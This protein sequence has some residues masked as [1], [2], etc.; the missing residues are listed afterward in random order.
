MKPRLPLT[1]IGG[2][3]GAGKTTLVNRWLREAEGQRIAVLVNDFGALNIDAALIAGARGD[4]IALTN[5][6]VC[7]QIGDDLSRAL[8]QVLESGTRFDAVVIEASGVSD[9]WRIA[10]L[11][12]AAPELALEGVIVLVDAAAAMA[13]ARDPLLADTLERQ[14][15]AADLVAINKVDSVTADELAR[16]REWVSSVA[17]RTP[18]YE[19]SQ[20]RLPRVLR[21]GLSLTEAREERQARGCPQPGCDHDDHSHHEAHDHGELFDT[22]SCRPAQ[23][24]DANALRTWLRDTPPGLLRLK[25]VLRTGEAAWS[26]IQFA[27]RHGAL[28]KADAPSDGAAVVAIGLRGHLPV[29]ALEAAF[30]APA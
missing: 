6:C 12:M 17:G 19:T 2:F 13:Q 3:L 5:G 4:T 25:G 20:S 10:Q 21:E 22:W 26:E 18:Q 8:I 16:V 24:F 29:A 15:R 9:P 28:R 7:C 23:V 27:G 14:L 11:G 1:V 30:A